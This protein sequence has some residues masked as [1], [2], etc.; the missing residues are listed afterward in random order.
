MKYFHLFLSISLKNDKNTSI[1]KSLIYKSVSKRFQWKH[2]FKASKPISKNF[3]QKIPFFEDMKCFH[4]ETLKKC[5]IYFHSLF[6]QA[7]VS[8]CFHWK[9][10]ENHRIFCQNRFRFHKLLRDFQFWK[11]YQTK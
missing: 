9:R 6:L 11:R 10:Y 2:L 1:H 5:F 3:S 4:M 7:I 8:K